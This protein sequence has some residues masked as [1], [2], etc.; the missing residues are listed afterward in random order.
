MDTQEIATAVMYPTSGLGIGRI[1]EPGYQRSLCRAYN[2]FIADYCKASPRLKA[3]ANLPVNDPV[4][5]VEEL[6]HAVTELGLVGGMLAAQ[7]QWEELRDIRVLS[8]LRRGPE[9][10]HPARDPCV[11]R[12]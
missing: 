8:A 11:R 3:V 4:A 6:R 2:E 7:G 12:R 1:R 5:A 10:E 9:A